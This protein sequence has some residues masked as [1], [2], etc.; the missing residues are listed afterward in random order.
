MTLSLLLPPIGIVLVAPAALTP[1]SARSRRSASSVKP[2]NVVSSPYRARG[3]LT[4]TVSTPSGLNPGSTANTRRKLA[5]SRPAPMS[6]TN[7]NPTCATTSARRS[8]RAP[9]PLVP[10]RPSSRS[11]AVRLAGSTVATGISPSTS[12]ITAAIAIV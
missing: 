6:S 4:D 1:G 2:R 9:R 10:V 8:V 5:N 12:P 11:T 7:A 3:R